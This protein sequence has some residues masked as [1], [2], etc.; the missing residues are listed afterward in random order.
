[1]CTQDPVFINLHCTA[2][3]WALDAD[4]A[5][6]FGTSGQHERSD[7][8]PQGWHPLVHW[9][10]GLCILPSPFF[11][12]PD[13]LHSNWVIVMAPATKVSTADAM[14]D[15]NKTEALW[16]WRWMNIMTILGQFFRRLCSGVGL[17]GSLF[18]T[19]RRERRFASSSQLRHGTWWTWTRF[20]EQKLSSLG[21]PVAWR[22]CDSCEDQ[23]R[24]AAE[25]RRGQPYQSPIWNL[26]LDTICGS[27]W[28]FGMPDC[29]R[30]R[31]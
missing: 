17:Q 2:G 23:G 9:W 5:W 25:G 20:G 10:S 18:G 28:P 27:C 24:R 14:K 31:M 29:T 13:L 12:S 22:W 8:E 30:I 4:V 3:A 6:R 11:Q 15:V 26:Q 16:R 21:Q 19:S 1:M 7:S